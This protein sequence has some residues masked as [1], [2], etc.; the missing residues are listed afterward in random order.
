MTTPTPT[1]TVDPKTPPPPLPP[2]APV[3][4]LEMRGIRKSFSGTEVLH[5]VDLQLTRG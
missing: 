1:P 3:P 5:G 2:P 4:L